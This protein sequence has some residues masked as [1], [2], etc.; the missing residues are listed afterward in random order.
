[1]VDMDAASSIDNVVPR[2]ETRDDFA[3]SHCVGNRRQTNV[4][5][6]CEERL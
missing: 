2:A 1:M 5:R 6:S 4:T 3:G